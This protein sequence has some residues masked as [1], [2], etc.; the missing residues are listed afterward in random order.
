M[1]L[2]KVANAGTQ[3]TG[4]FSNEGEQGPRQAG[5]CMREVGGDARDI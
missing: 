2:M 3:K 1:T 5:T 4:G